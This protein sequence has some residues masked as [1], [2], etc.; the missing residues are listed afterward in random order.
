MNLLSFEK[1]IIKP[2]KIELIIANRKDLVEKEP[3]YSYLKEI[4]ADVPGLDEP[5]DKKKGVKKTGKVKML[6]KRAPKKSYSNMGESN[7]EEDDFGESDSD[8]SSDEDFEEAS[9]DKKEVKGSKKEKE[10]K[11]LRDY[12][13]GF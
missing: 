2:S 7:D 3:N 1:K 9:E 13:E 5:Q 11:E 8:F 6:K 12:V 4:F 10:E